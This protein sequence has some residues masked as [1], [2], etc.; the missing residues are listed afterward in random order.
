MQ[1]SLL[2]R[3]DELSGIPGESL[4]GARDAFLL[5]LMPAP[6][7]TVISGMWSKINQW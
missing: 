7:R 6:Q 2:A 5:N 4:L 1:Q 3:Q